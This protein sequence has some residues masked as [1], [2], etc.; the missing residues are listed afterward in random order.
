MSLAL[1]RRAATA[2]TRRHE[3]GLVGT[4]LRLEQWWLLLAAVAIAVVAVLVVARPSLFGLPSLADVDGARLAAGMTV[5]A[6]SHA[7]RFVRLALLLHHPGLRMRRVLQVHLF[8]SAL[9]VL[10]PFKLSELVRIREVGVIAGSARTGLLAVWLERTLDAAVLFVLVAITAISVPDSLDLVTPFLVGLTA[11]V[12]ITVVLITVVPE[13]VR[14]L[15]LHLVRR[16]Y[17]PRSVA[18]LRVLR[19]GLAA[20]QEAPSMLRGRLPT[21]IVLSALIWAAEIAAVSL[22]LP[23]VGARVSE[24]SSG[25]LALLATLSSGTT[26]IMSGAGDRLAEVLADF[27]YRADVD[28]YR[29]T[30][31]LPVLVAGAWATALYVRWRRSG[32]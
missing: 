11:F 23:D 25:M 4:V 2:V 8:T 5:Y 13:N 18:V 7:L 15:M 24:L 10:L 31:V 6:L 22:T 29:L 26:P 19:G 3:P 28:L 32:R 27:G 12:T 30:I 21:L 16:P 1:E 20:L 17:G 9:G 14:E